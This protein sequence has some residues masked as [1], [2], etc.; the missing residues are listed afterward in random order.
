[1]FREVSLVVGGAWVDD[2]HFGGDDVSLKVGLNWD[3]TKC[4]LSPLGDP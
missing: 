3:M 4:P 1:M 2:S